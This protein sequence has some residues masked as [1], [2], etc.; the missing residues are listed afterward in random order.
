MIRIFALLLGILFIAAGVVLCGLLTNWFRYSLS[1]EA[2]FVVV[3]TLIAILI[4]VWLSY[5]SYTRDSVRFL[6]ID[7]V[8]A[9][10]SIAIV[11][12]IH[13]EAI[14]GLPHLYLSHNEKGPPAGLQTQRGPVRYWIEIENPFSNQHAEFLVLVM[15]IG[16][17]LRI[18]IQVFGEP[19]KGYTSAAKPADWGTLSVTS[20]PNVAILTVGSYL[21]PSNEKFRVDLTTKTATKLPNS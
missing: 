9:V 1:L 2:T 17:E 5:V 21:S 3:P 15:D 6:E 4:V 19:T 16:K 12:L 14:G 13:H 18:P 11:L 20:D 8:V 10:I 7:A